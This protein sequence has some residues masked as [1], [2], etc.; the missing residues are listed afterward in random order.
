MNLNCFQEIRQD[1][2]LENRD[3]TEVDKDVHDVREAIERLKKAAEEKLLFLPRQVVVE[4][5]RIN[6]SS[7]Q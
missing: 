4:E 1:L 5:E 7:C 3:Y 2:R 6:P